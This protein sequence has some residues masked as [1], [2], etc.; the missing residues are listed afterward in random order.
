MST[1]FLILQRVLDP[2][3]DTVGMT[4]ARPDATVYENI[5]WA[6]PLSLRA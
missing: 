1:L 6:N 4:S 3:Q 2:K 5:V